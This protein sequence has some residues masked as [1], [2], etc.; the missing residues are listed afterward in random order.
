VKRRLIL[1]GAVVAVAGALAAGLGISARAQDPQ[2]EIAVV[3]HGQ[4]SD[5]FWTVVRNGINQAARE[6]GTRVTYRAP[7]VY[8]ARRMR[9]LIDAVVTSRPDGLVVSIPDAQ[10]LAPALRR[11]TKARIPVLAINAG[12]DTYRRLGGLVFVGQA[13]YDA[14]FAAGRRM[15]DAGVRDAICVQHQPGVAVLDQRCRRFAAGL[16]R[17]RGRMRVL[18]VRLQNQREATR[19]IADALASRSVDGIL[20]LGPGGASPALA[21]LRATRRLGKVVFGTFDLA[22]DILRAVKAGQILFAIDQQPFLQGYLP[23]VLL[24]QY[25]RYGLLPAAG[26]HVKTGPHFVT[27]RE[28]ARVLRLTRRGI[29]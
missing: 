19:R 10:V 1:V 22:P 28:A 6:T 17:R 27:K 29:R 15:A 20:T 9:D 8:D 3:S 7:D 18:P 13:E 11:A 14:G 5:P 4:A 2:V 25:E 16:A 12:E 26:S 21:A 24:T 23:V